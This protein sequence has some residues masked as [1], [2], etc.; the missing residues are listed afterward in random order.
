MTKSRNLSENS[1][2]NQ[3]AVKEKKNHHSK[4]P[5]ANLTLSVI[6]TNIRSFLPKRQLVSNVVLSSTSNVL[7]LTETWLHSNIS[8]DEVLAD[9]PNFHIYRKDRTDGRGGGVLVAV[10]QQLSSSVLHIDSDIEILWIIC[11]AVPRT[12]LL[13]VCYRPPQSNPDFP[14]KLNS[15]LNTLTRVHPNADIVLFGDFNYP[16]ID[17]HNYTTFSPEATNFVDVCLNFN[18]SQLITEPTRVA[19]SSSNTLDLIL[20]NNPDSMTSIT[21][22]REISDH[23]VVH[24]TFNFAPLVCET[25]KKTIRLYDKANYE[26]INSELTRFFPVFETQFSNHPV[27]ENWLL[28]K[29]KVLELI[30]KYIPVCSF[31]ANKNKPWFNKSL[32][33]LENK[34]KRYFRAAKQSNNPLLWDKYYSAET[35][36]L[37]AIQNAKYKFFHNDLSCMLTQNPKQFWRVINPEQKHTITLANENNDVISN[38]E[39]A[40]VFNTAFASVFTNDHAMPPIV[41]RSR[42]ITSELPMPDIVFSI[43][44]IISCIERLKLTSSAGFDEI[45]SKFLLNTKNISAAFL[46]L[47]FSQSLSTGHLPDDWKVGKVVPIH[48]SGSKQSPLNYRPISLTSIPCKIIEHVIYSQIMT[49]LDLN[50]FFN[51]SQHGF[52]KGLSCETQ[53][54]NFLHDLHLNLDCNQQ[55]DAIFLDFAKAFDKVSHQLLLFKLSSLNIN[56]NVL[57]WIAAFLRNRSQSVFVN[58]CVSNPLPVTS[59]VPQGSVLGPLLFLIYINDLPL[60]VSCHIRMFADDCVIYRTITN[61]SEQQALQHDLNSIQAWCDH[62]LMTLNPTKC[63]SLSFSRRQNPLTFPYTLGNVDLDRV[64]SY[65]YLGVTLSYDLTWG[66]HVT[67]IIAGANKSLGFLKRHLRHAPKHLKLLAYKSIIRPKLEYAAAIWSP[68]QAYLTNSLE[69]LQNRAVRFIHSSYSYHV[70][71]SS[72]K[73]ESSLLTLA[74]RR[75]IATLALFHKFYYSSRDRPDFITTPARISHRTGH[76]LQVTRPRSHTKT[77]SASF[78]PRASSE[79]NDLSHSTA[80]ITCPSLFL[81][82][83]TH[84]LSRN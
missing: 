4:V 66:A 68:P 33:R 83:V 80:A 60:H 25:Y 61:P 41:L 84:C 27:Q 21:H 13:G 39:C 77:F 16:R 8:D 78:F 56:P 52:R 38:A 23:K 73:E 18:L 72:L 55:T 53:L 26:A 58:E 79:W 6:F 24:A 3:R 29:S 49:F 75:R 65:K 40:D 48:K 82:N 46:C 59:G 57:N 12:V 28:F 32:K 36:Y 34:K 15:I 47:L 43:D 71:V 19:Q 9:L 5:R 81:Q 37:T 69:A 45:N 54:A 22:L 63:K 35:E 2:S 10:N 1:N 14:C 70:S 20:T 74:L 31:R 67:N 42:C 51:P 11:R 62:W 64:E 76:A 30:E 50:D 7:I 17:W 44:G